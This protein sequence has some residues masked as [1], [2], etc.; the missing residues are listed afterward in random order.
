MFVNRDFSDD[1]GGFLKSLGFVGLKLRGQVDADEVSSYRLNGVAVAGVN[2]WTIAYNSPDMFGS[3]IIPDRE[4]PPFKGLWLDLVEKQLVE[5][6]KGSKV[7]GF[8]ME[9][10]TGTYGISWH[11]DGRRKRQLLHLHQEVVIDEGKPLDYERPAL[12]Q[13]SMAEYETVILDIAGSIVS[14][15]DLDT[16]EFKVFAYKRAPGE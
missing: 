6:S 2:G 11:V 1:F 5:L 13:V 14:W 10:S 12:S 7:F 9:G 16:V 4:E 8:L 3:G 15:D